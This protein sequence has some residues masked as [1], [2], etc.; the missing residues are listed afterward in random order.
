MLLFSFAIDTN[1]VTQKLLTTRDYCNTVMDISGTHMANVLDMD[2][3]VAI[4]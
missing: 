1:I 3:Q 2:K 4:Q